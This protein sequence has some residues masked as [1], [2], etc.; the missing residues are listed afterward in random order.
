[1]ENNKLL[2]F[3]KYI[4]QQAIRIEDRSHIENNIY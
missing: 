2:N 1:M 4:T 3:Y